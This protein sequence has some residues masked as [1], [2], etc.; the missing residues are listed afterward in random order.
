MDRSFY[1][2]RYTYLKSFEPDF[3]FMHKINIIVSQTYR[4]GT[5]GRYHHRGLG[6]ALSLFYAREIVLY[7]GRY[8]FPSAATHELIL[9]VY[10]FHP[11]TCCSGKCTEVHLDRKY[12]SRG[13]CIFLSAK[14]WFEYFYQP[15]NGS[16]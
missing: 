2:I 8:D 13:K 6:S 5:A 10:S 16:I 14:K 11:S 1:E 12:S 9:S 4:A 15:R 7:S 3:L